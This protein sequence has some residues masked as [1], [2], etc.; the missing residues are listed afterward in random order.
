MPLPRIRLQQRQHHGVVRVPVPGQGPPHDP[1][2]MQIPHGH[3]I[4]RPVT[5]LHGLRGRPHPHPRH[6]LQPSPRI[7]RGHRPRLLQPRGNPY[8]T[9]NRGSPLVVDP[10]PMPLPRRDQRPRARRRHHPH[11]PANRTRPRRR[12]PELPYQQPPGPIRLVGRHLL[13]QHRRN[14]RL[15]HQPG[16]RQPQPRP[17]M[18]GDSDKPMPR[19][20][21]ARIISGTQHLRQ[22]LQQPVT[23]GPPGLPP[24]LTPVRGH[25]QRPRPNR[26]KTGPPH[27]P[28]RIHP[29]RRIPGP[30]PQRPKHQP[31]IKHPVRHPPPHPP[32]RRRTLPRHT[33]R[34]DDIPT[35]HSRTSGPRSKTSGH[36]EFQG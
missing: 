26:R 35:P 5:P 32:G 15:Q 30:P 6:H 16:P 34:R 20:E 36:G 24:H 3:R 19:H 7:L 10:G 33:P 28:V 14:Q 9:Q 25:P 8:G 17:P 1:R 29:K 13:L 2:Q 22:P 23:P 27:S 4:R 11:P 21:R 31:K 12:H 18:L